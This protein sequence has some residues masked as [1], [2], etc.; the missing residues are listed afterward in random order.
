MTAPQH[1]AQRTLALALLARRTGTAAG[2][3]AIAAAAGRAYDELEQV[4]EPVIGAV[5]LAAMTDRALHLSAR[6]Y[7]W[8]PSRK[9]GADGIQFAQVIEALTAQDPVRAS[10]AAAAGLGTIIALLATFIGQPLAARLVRQAWPDASS[11]ADTEET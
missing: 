1:T 10:E 7:P 3:D 8:L 6:E 2:A 9:P 11:I 5:G 4:L